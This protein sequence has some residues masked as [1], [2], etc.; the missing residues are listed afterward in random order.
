MWTDNLKINP[1][2]ALLDEEDTALRFFA[3]RELLDFGGGNVENLWEL[4]EPQKILQKQRTDGAWVYKGSRPGDEFGENY[5][6]L[7][8]WKNLRFLVEMYGFT[9]KHP[10]IQRAAEFIFACQTPE[11]DIRGILAN[12]YMPYYMGAI[13][14]ILIKAGYGEDERIQKGIQWL[15][16]M[17]QADGG[18]IIPLQVY[19]IQEFYRVYNQP[20][21][22]LEK[23]RPFSHMAS[24]MVIRAFAAHESTSK[25]PEALEASRLLKSRMF[26]PDEY[27]SRQS[28]DYWYKLQF[29]F[30][31]TSLLTVMD[32][33]M[34]MSF[35]IDQEIQAGLEW[36]LQN[37]EPSGTW[38]SSYGGLKGTNSNLWVTFAVCRILKYYLG[39]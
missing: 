11:G 32:T 25:L 37:Q 23:E 14:E 10:A 21:I 33:L 39:G 29:P 22:Q 1:L 2:V 28:V 36:F 27:T 16:D 34:R 9:N 26:K 6:L 3:E 5:E 38:R 19:K 35:P 18:W 31:W 12:Q 13:M 8:T 7:E 15:L 4:K 17:R 24:G 30:W 20:P